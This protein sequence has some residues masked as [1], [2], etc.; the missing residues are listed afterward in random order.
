MVVE[1]V[2][3]GKLNRDARR[4]IFSLS[5]RVFSD[6]ETD[7]PNF[8]LLFL[9]ASNSAEVAAG[10]LEVID[11]AEP[12]WPSSTEPKRAARA[13][14]LS[15]GCTDEGAVVTFLIETAFW[16]LEVLEAP[17]EEEEEEVVEAPVALPGVAPAPLA[18]EVVD[19]L[20]VLVRGRDDPVTVA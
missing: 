2:D 3:D 6:G 7:S 8:S 20:V 13:A 18:V 17:T 15:N 19:V 5:S 16:E 10:T 12:A 9:R 11:L 1:A 4:A 14:N